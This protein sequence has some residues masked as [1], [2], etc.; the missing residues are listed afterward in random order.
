MA[1]TRGSS[2]LITTKVQPLDI[3][4][5]HLAHSPAQPQAG[6]VY[7]G[8]WGLHAHPC[9]QAG[10]DLCSASGCPNAPVREKLLAPWP[11]PRSLLLVML[12]PQEPATREVLL[13]LA[14]TLAMYWV[15]LSLEAAIRRGSM[16]RAMDRGRMLLGGTLCLRNRSHQVAGTAPDEPQRPADDAP[17]CTSLWSTGTPHSLEPAGLTSPGSARTHHPVQSHC[18]SCCHFQS[19]FEGL[20]QRLL[21]WR[22]LCWVPLPQGLQ[23]EL[24]FP[25]TLYVCP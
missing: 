1:T 12:Q 22:P 13:N 16:S 9:L 17:P 20:A 10:W 18:R 7:G 25:Q 21:A 8:A 6:R 5:R 24:R 19:A 2:V 3:V 11:V 23:G 15:P 14:P 4:A